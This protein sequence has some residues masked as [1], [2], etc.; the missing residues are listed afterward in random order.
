ME[1]RLEAPTQDQMEIVRNGRNLKRF[2]LRT[3]FLLTS[4]MQRDF[5]KSVCCDRNAPHRFFSVLKGYCTSDFI[6]IGGLTPIS[7]ENRTAEISLLLLDEY[8]KK[9]SGE[10]ACTL[11]LNEAFNIMNLEFVYGECYHSNPYGLKF[12][13]KIAE[14]YNAETTTLPKRKY[15]DGQYHGSFYFCISKENFKK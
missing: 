8:T 3:P 2:G 9:G 14:K 10:K 6:G 15:W 13:E 5:Y 12:W 4:E 11:I 1:L 7:W